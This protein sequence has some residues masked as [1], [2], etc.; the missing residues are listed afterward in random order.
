MRKKQFQF[1]SNA[2][3]CIENLLIKTQPF[4]ASL[5]VDDGDIL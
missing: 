4:L 1:Y 5:S 3:L 2:N